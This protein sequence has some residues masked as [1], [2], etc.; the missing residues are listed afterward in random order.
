MRILKSGMTPEA[1]DA[2]VIQLAEEGLTY[3]AI[4]ERLLV[5]R[6]RVKQIIDA[7]RST[8]VDVQLPKHMRQAA[9]MAIQATK[10]LKVH[11]QARTALADGADPKTVVALRAY[12]ANKRKHCRQMGI[13]FELTFGDLWPIPD[14]CP[15]LGIP[16][17]LFATDRDHAYS[18]DQIHPRQGYVKGNVVAVSYRANRIKNDATPDELQRIAKFY[19]NP[20]SADPQNSGVFL[21]LDTYEDLP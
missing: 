16:I 5:K 9:R 4:G 8:G 1:R 3:A 14:T 18:L 7:I 20:S 12:I 11:E 15:A 19:S 21:D 2:L 13:P 17:S 10:P 6:Q